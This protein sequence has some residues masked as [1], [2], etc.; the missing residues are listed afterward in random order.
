MDI[1]E[2]ESINTLLNSSKVNDRKKGAKIVGDKNLKQL[3]D[4]LWETY[5][6]Q[7]NIPSSWEAQ[8]Q[9]IN[10][11]GIIGYNPAKET[12]YNICLQNKEHD[13][14]TTYAAM[15]YCRI[16]RN[17]TNDITPNLE[18]LKFGKF[19]VVNGA[20]RVLAAD[21]VIPTEKEMQQL[22]AFTDSIPVKREKGYSDIRTGLAAAAAGWK[23]KTATSFLE[24]CA[25]DADS[26]LSK[27]AKNSLKGKYTK[28]N[29]I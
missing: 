17:A 11:L 23:S 13:M 21:Q 27:V 10:S 3:G 12:F 4:P 22:I 15:A 14:V 7:T 18:L 19:A 26:E 28:I 9:M 5:K 8:I 16:V 24:I 20:F 25:A 6:K 1:A 29:L 2:K